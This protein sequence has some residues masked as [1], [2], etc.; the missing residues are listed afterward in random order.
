MDDSANGGRLSPEDFQQMN[1]LL[2]R[3]CTYELDQWENIQTETPYG[4]V[5]V[6]FSRQRLPGFEAQTFHPF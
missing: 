1:A 6:T 5:Y 2:R 3:F 4:P